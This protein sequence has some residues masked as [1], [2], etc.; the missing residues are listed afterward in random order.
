MTCGGAVNVTLI[1]GALALIAIAWA[2][3][4]RAAP[5]ACIIPVS[6]YPELGAVDADVVRREL[7]AALPRGPYTEWARGDA[8]R[9]HFSRMTPAEIQHHLRSHR[10]VAGTPHAH[11]WKLIPIIHERTQTEHAEHFSETIAMLAS[12]HPINVGISTLEP[13]SETGRHRDYDYRYFRV[14]IP[15]IVPRGNDVGLVIDRGVLRWRLGRT[16]IIDDTFYHNAF[17]RTD[18][19]RIVLLVDVPRRK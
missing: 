7:V 19:E 12:L 16:F 5:P 13:H 4:T 14:H 2:L 3:W 8:P 10:L 18:D 17:N 15:L 11:R 9:P 1:V 6:R